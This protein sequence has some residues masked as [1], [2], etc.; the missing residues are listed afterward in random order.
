MTIHFFCDKCGAQISKDDVRLHGYLCSTCS[1]I[2]F[3][4]FIAEHPIANYPP[5]TKDHSERGDKLTIAKIRQSPEPRPLYRVIEE[6]VAMAMMFEMTIEIH[7]VSEKGFFVIAGKDTICEPV[8]YVE[9]LEDVASTLRWL[10]QK[11][12]DGDV[13]SVFED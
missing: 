3:R 2:E 8:A 11:I 7:Q 13:D 6:G 4:S 1:E 10:A 5:L 12:E 9:S